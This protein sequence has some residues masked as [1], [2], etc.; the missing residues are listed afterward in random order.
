VNANKTNRPAADYIMQINKLF[1]AYT[2]KATMNRNPIVDKYA[3]GNKELYMLVM[4][5]QNGS[6]ASYTLDLGTADSAFIY[7]P[8]A[9]RA[10]MNLLARKTNNGKVQIPVTETPVFVTA[11][12][13]G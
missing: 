1:G 11:Y 2:Y 3:A 6:S 5:T 12:R 10:N 8:A 9:G 4:P 13:C 7:Q